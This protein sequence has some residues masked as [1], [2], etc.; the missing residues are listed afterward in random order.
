MKAIGTWIKATA[1]LSIALY[2]TACTKGP[3]EQPLKRDTDAIQLTYNE[4]S[5]AKVSVRYNGQWESRIECTEED[6]TLADSW[7]SVSPENGSGNGSDYQFVTITAKRNPGNKRTGTLHLIAGGESHSISVTQEDGHFSVS[8]PVISGVLKSGSASNA[9][10]LINY[11][12]A[13]GG[14]KVSVTSKLSGSSQGLSIQE[15]YE[16]TIEKEGNG[17]I[18][19]PI[20]GT[21]ET[22][23]D[24]ICTTILSMDGKEIFNGNITASISS[25]NEIFNMGF[26]L[27]VWGG[28][29]PENKP[30]TTPRSDNKQ[31]GK[32]FVGT[33]P[34]AGTLTAGTDGAQ[35]AFN[36]MTEEYRTNRG[37][38]GWS[39]SKVYEHPGY[40]KIG[41]GSASGWIMTPE[42]ANLSASPE[43]VVI[44]VD[45][46]R[47]DNEEG[48]YIVSAEGAGTISNG[49]VNTANLPTQSSS[50]DRK[51]RTL[52]FTVKNATN[53]TRIRIG[54]EGDG[55]GYRINIDNI[56]VMG[57]E[58][59]V[60]TEQL[61]AP[62]A[63]EILTTPS[64]NS[65]KFMWA[66]IEGATSYNL[67][68]ASQASPEFKK[69]VSTPESSYLFENLVPGLYL[70]TVQ[71]V[72]EPNPIFNSE[73]TE[74]TAGTT[75]FVA[76]KLKAPQNVK[77]EDITPSGAKISWDMVNGA[78]KY[79]VTVKQGESP[80]KSEIT[81]KTELS[82]SE[83]AKGSV[84]TVAVKA[85]AG[86]GETEHEFD[87]D[88]TSVQFE[89]T[90][91]DPLS[92]PSVTLYHTSYGLA[93]VSFEYDR[94]QQEDTKFSIQLCNAGG[95]VIREYT[96]WN[97]N[98]KYTK[99]GTRF[100][101]GGLD[102][103]TAYQVKVKRISLDANQWEDSDWSSSLSFTTNQMPDKSGYLLWNDFDQHPWGGNGPMIA[104]GID[105]KAK[106]S[107]F[108]FLNWKDNTS[109]SIA[110][111]VKNMDNLGNG[112]GKNVSGQNITSKYHELFM[113]G[114]DSEELGKNDKEKA[115]GTVYLCGGMMK[116]GTGSSYGRLTLPAFAE[117]NAPSSLEIS[118]SA[119]P[120]CEPN[121]D[122]GSL[123]VEPS[124]LNGETFNIEILS[125]P[126]TIKTV[127]GQTV[128]KTQTSV[129]NKTLSEMD[130][131]TNGRFELTPH[132][133]V[134]EGATSET[135]ISIYTNG[136]SDGRMWIDDIKV[137]KM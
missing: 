1:I 81:E 104:F 40:L 77:V 3:E 32:E 34:V 106:D 75:G 51:W 68:L 60:V 76:E 129:K 67:T 61:P 137:K 45:F 87:S 126:G 100:M 62:E 131:E 31:A 114:W 136:N 101:F 97:F 57:A 50:G 8:E 70:F 59:A 24:V 49:T 21:P 124:V 112:V 37:I 122:S 117:L 55:A 20:S 38:T 36:T 58:K 109:W 69:T 134:I 105:P 11:D 9:E 130:A 91:P 86:T 93:V 17:N 107:E 28:N 133:I 98:K 73:I 52:T 113:P 7:F 108:D 123:T 12:K 2:L 132:T 43:E 82:V 116:F 19:I 14:E 119:G 111:P 94:S 102:S 79:K 92:A 18:S 16:T 22:I 88:E 63:E 128:G 33:E 64:E 103:N 110:S 118:L 29:Y 125:G 96:K 78:G 42:L 54:A 26:D 27:F 15:K 47:F 41:T 56:K 95:S 25:S 135:R 65:I 83:L 23:G 74:T 30:G 10:L 5:S 85:L 39:G 4:G 121:N 35:D 84:Y 6:G 99:H 127:D 66:A 89:T 71:A 90:N 46:M 44:S 80:V 53:K 120:Y 115:T 13:F 48:T 72:Y